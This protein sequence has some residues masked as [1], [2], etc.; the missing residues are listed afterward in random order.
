MCE[1]ERR[2]VATAL[3]FGNTRTLALCHLSCTALRRSLF[4]GG[5]AGVECGEQACTAD[6]MPG[7]LSAVHCMPPSGTQHEG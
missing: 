3:A 1:G 6:S 7:R 2:H 5:L 4:P